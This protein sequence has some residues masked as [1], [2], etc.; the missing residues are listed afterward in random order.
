MLKINNKI[1]P[2]QVINIDIEITITYWF[3]R[4]QV[5]RET[6]SVDDQKMEKTLMYF[7]QDSLFD[8]S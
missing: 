3:S 6:M 5:W 4:A 8:I 7:L 1:Q 2:M